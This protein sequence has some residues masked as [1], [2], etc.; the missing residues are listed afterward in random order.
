M[1]GEVIVSGLKRLYYD[2]DDGVHCDLPRSVIILST[3]GEPR[4]SYL[5]KFA[6]HLVLSYD[7]VIDENDPYAYNGEMAS[8]V[9][10]LVKKI[11]A[12]DSVCSLYV[13]CDYGESRSAGLAAA[14]IRYL[15]GEDLYLWDSPSY[16]PNPLVYRKT[17]EALG[18]DVT[19]EDITYLTEINQKTFHEA[20]PDRK[21]EDK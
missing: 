18:I 4:W 17:C 20:I 6:D 14:V 2:I 5:D 1:T 19:D 9:A 15:G 21:K 8:R 10:E 11:E 13:V 3:S 7:D 12:D 16:H